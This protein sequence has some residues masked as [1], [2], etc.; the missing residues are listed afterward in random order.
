M[1]FRHWYERSSSVDGWE[2]TRIKDWKELNGGEEQFLL[3][4]DIESQIVN[5][6]SFQNFLDAVEF[7]LN[8][9]KL[10][11]AFTFKV[12]KYGSRG[13]HERGVEVKGSFKVS[14]DVN[15]DLPKNN[16]FVPNRE[17]SVQ[18][19]FGQGAYNHD[20]YN[21]ARGFGLMLK[22][23]DDSADK[24][25]FTFNAGDGTIFWNQK[26]FWSIVKRTPLP[27][28]DGINF[29]KRKP[30]FAKSPQAWW[31]SI[32]ANR[33]RV[34]S[35]AHLSYFTGTPFKFVADDGKP[36]LIKFQAFP[37]KSNGTPSSEGAFMPQGEEMKRPWNQTGGKNDAEKKDANYLSKDIRNRLDEQQ[38]IRYYL[39]AQVWEQ[40]PEDSPEVQSVNAQWL[41]PWINLGE[42]EITNYVSDDEGRKFAFPIGVR[43]NTGVIELPDL[44]NGKNGASKYAS[45]LYAR[46]EIYDLSIFLRR[47]R[48]RLFGKP[49]K[50]I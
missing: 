15:D 9:F 37:H 17:F 13:T 39:R 8:Q 30:V 47:W 12:L 44:E 45:L 34:S 32:E 5:P 3:Q 25:A 35:M 2:D 10:S 40:S 31:G 50:S 36:R 22:Q 14:G 43:S 46:Q 26:S 27:G 4:R 28:K 19:R 16:F 18:A 1:E 11:L 7:R 29:D 20:S 38:I 21:V 49:N 48:E 23:I 33:S 42:I 6:S 41:T 24:H